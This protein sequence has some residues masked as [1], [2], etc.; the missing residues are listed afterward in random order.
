MLDKFNKLVAVAVAMATQRSENEVSVN[1][2]DVHIEENS[3]FVRFGMWR[4]YAVYYP[5]E[6]QYMPEYCMDYATYYFGWKDG[7]WVERKE[8]S[9]PAFDK[10][11]ETEADEL[12]F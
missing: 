4:E 11:V 3:G 7:E 8:T 1:G 12:P 9:I 6:N 2:M 5:D 10:L